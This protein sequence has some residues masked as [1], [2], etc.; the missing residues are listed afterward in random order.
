[1]RC[2]YFKNVERQEVI[3]TTAILTYNIDIILKN[4]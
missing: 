1:M 4:N 3:E 2:L